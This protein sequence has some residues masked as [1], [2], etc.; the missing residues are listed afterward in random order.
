MW[1]ISGGFDIF[2]IKKKEKVCF[3][4]WGFPRKNHCIILKIPMNEIK[5]IRIITRV[6]ERSIF[7]RTFTYVIEHGF[8]PWTRIKDNLCNI[9]F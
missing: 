9:S 3:L 6:Q 4:C 7:T 1:D 8:I 2:D 5:S